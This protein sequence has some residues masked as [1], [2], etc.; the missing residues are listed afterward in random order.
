[1]RRS[2]LSSNFANAC[3]SVID[4]QMVFGKLRKFYAGDHNILTNHKKEASIKTRLFGIRIYF[5]RIIFLVLV[6]LPAR[7][8]VK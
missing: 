4:K 5:I 3:T 7:N 1:M 8:L 2:I 6:C